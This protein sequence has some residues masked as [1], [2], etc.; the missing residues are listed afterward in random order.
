MIEFD[1]DYLSSN[2]W[3]CDAKT[4][5]LFKTS[6]CIKNKLVVKMSLI[7]CFSFRNSAY[8]RPRFWKVCSRL[9]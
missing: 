4:I 3:K 9:A 1:L 6:A 5:L 2:F 7:N 8:S